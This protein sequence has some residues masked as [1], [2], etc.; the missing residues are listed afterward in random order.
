LIKNK[1]TFD[2]LLKF[3]SD[4]ISWNSI[5]NI[6]PTDSGYTSLYQ[7]LTY[8]ECFG[9]GE[10]IDSLEKEDTVGILDALVD[11]IFTAFQWATLSGCNLQEEDRDWYDNVVVGNT[12]KDFYLEE[13]KRTILKEDAFASQTA[14]I[15]LL[16][17]YSEDFD[18]VGAFNLVLE[19]NTTKAVHVS[20][21]VD[22]EQEIAYIESQGRYGDITCE[23][24]GEY[25]VFKAGQDVRDG[26]VFDKAKI[27][28]SSLFLSVE[29]LGGLGFF[30]Y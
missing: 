17:S 22:I 19:S 15:H 9:E 18:I 6:K 3:Q 16:E 29:D 20:K 8:E 26:V 30:V 4:V 14:L 21:G 2:N 11:L 10:L 28:K 27:I 24:S 25:F 5:F 13:L 7:Q 23:R 12:A 1:L